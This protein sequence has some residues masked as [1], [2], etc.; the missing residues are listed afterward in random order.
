MFQKCQ[1]QT[2]LKGFQDIVLSDSRKEK[3]IY[4]SKK[5]YEIS[6]SNI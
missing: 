2:T 4:E 6:L 1:Y 3:E 5:E